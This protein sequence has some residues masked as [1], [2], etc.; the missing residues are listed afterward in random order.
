VGRGSTDERRVAS[1]KKKGEEGEVR[2][3]EGKGEMVGWRSRKGKR[4][5]EEGSTS[6]PLNQNSPQSLI[7]PVFASKHALCHHVGLLN[8]VS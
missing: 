4:R 3:E 1:R 5:V 7:S 8:N 6:R 2:G